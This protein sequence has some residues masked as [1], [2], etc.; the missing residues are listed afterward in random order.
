MLLNPAYKNHGEQPVKYI[1]QTQAILTLSNG[2]KNSQNL[3]N[4][5]GLRYCSFTG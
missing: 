2:V 3:I 4:F 5:V 1:N